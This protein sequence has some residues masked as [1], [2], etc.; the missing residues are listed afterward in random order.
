MCSTEKGHFQSELF[1]PPY[2]RITSESKGRDDSMSIAIGLIGKDGIVLATDS[3]MNVST[4][5]GV[6]YDDNNS[7]KLWKL[8]DNLG[9]ASTGTQQG[10]RQ[11]LL[12]MCQRVLRKNGTDNLS[13]EAI[14][15]LTDTIRNDFMNQ[16]KAFG[17]ELA[18]Q[19]LTTKIAIIVA[20]Y[21]D[22]NNPAI[23]SIRTYATASGIPFIRDIRHDYCIYSADSTAENLIIKTGV[24]HRMKHGLEINML[25]KLAGLLIEET[26]MS[27]KAVGG[28]IQMATI[29]K[30]AGFSFVE[31]NEVKQIADKANTFT[32]EMTEAIIKWLGIT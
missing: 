11:Y 30:N 4:E 29:T 3:K 27:N 10:Y 8:A 24:I 23:L 18:R 31:D 25:K 7:Q 17:D 32:L 21:D 14:K 16:V 12:E 28:K 26:K 6:N 19:L 15:S 22:D 2:D 5:T 1:Y 9:W 20:G 13:E